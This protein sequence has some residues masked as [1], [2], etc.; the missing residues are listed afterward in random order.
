L[1][2]KLRI[3]KRYIA[4]Y[5]GKW[6]QWIQW[7]TKYMHIYKYHIYIYAC[8]YLSIYLCIYLSSY[9]SVYIYICIYVITVHRLTYTLYRYT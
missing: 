5:C 6:I 1:G 7:H 4:F 9:L 8:I 3:E 2:I